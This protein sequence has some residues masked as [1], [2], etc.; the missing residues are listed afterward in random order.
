MF[1]LK[2]LLLTLPFYLFIT[3]NCYCFFFVRGLEIVGKI[4]YNFSQMKSFSRQDL[5]QDIC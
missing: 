1:W 3:L 4:C 5:I 2:S